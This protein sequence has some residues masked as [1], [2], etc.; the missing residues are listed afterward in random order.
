MFFFKKS[1]I[2]LDCFTS[3]SYV[4]EACPIQKSIYSMP[5]WWKKL[6]ATYKHDFYD[7]STMKTCA[8]LVDLFKNSVTIKLWSDLKLKIEGDFIKWQ[9]SDSTTNMGQHPPEQ[10][11]DFMSKNKYVHFKIESPWCFRTKEDISWL[12]MQSLYN[13]EDPE[14]IVVLPGCINF[15]QVNDTHIN[16][17]TPLYDREMLLEFNQPMVQILPLSE[18]RV[19]IKNHLVD[20]N[21]IEKIRGNYRSVSFSYGFRKFL[22]SKENSKGK[23]PFH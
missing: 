3:L 10:R 7:F 18:K 22:S 16:F 23:C 13:F 8:G 12:W 21:E 20:K 1:K 19:E 15:S 6:G 5:N 9:F 2:V 4:Y 17:M 14:D 11:G